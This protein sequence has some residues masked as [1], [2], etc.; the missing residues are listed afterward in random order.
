VASPAAAGEP[1]G[2]MQHPEAHRCGCWWRRLGSG[3]RRRPRTARPTADR[4][5][6]ADCSPRCRTGR[7]PPRAR[8]GCRTRHAVATSSQP[9]SSDTTAVLR[10]SDRSP[11]LGLRLIALVAATAVGLVLDGTCWLC[12]GR[13][14]R[15]ANGGS[16]SGTHR[17]PVSDNRRTRPP[18]ALLGARADSDVIA[19]LSPRTT[20]VV[21]ERA[22]LLPP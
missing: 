3:S 14:R 4:P 21:T 19:A 22:A 17:R 1:G 9:S 6:A 12:H 8:R 18:L 5:G 2:H 16:T 13:G 15:L 20:P 11:P 10:G 7:T